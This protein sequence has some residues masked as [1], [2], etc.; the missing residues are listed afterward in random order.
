MNGVNFATLDLNL[1]RVFLAIWDT[2]NLTAA[3]ERLHLTQ[4]AVSHALRRLRD[5]LGDPLFVR[6]VNAMIPTDGATRLEPAL[7]QA[8]SL[9]QRAVQEGMAFDPLR[10]QRLFRIAMS[11]VS[12]FVLLP[13]V[14]A[15]LERC[16]PG[17]RIE[18]VRID[19]GSVGGQLR[20]GEVDMALGYLPGLEEGCVSELLGRDSFVCLVREGHPLEARRL[21]VTD[22]AQLRFM[23]AGPEAPGHQMAETWLDGL[24]VRRNVGLRLAHFTLAP[25]IVRNT[26]LAVIFPRS[27]AERV[28]HAGGFRLV[29]LPDGAPNIEVKSYT[30]AH[31]ASD[32]G[33]RWLQNLFVR[34]CGWGM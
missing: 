30:H 26:D 18:S 19:P 13:P 17:I 5:D 2:R 7:R 22:F 8:V 15:E 16:A 27:M 9:I 10:T 14:L 28:N 11:D 34:H 4:P 29:E 21:C 33:I 31:F 23:Y 1:I 25:E 24:G 3:G 12:E 20:T 6:S 32:Q